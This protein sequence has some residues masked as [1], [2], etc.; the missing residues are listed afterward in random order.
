MAQEDF[1]D[2]AVAI[3]RLRDPND[4]V[5]DWD[6]VRGELLRTNAS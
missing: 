6:Q 2:L 3:E 1:D 5:L 4:P